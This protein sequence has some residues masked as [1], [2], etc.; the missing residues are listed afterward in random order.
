MRRGV[1][2]VASGALV[3]GAGASVGA[4][5]AHMS[6]GWA[7]EAALESAADVVAAPTAEVVLPKPVVVTRIK[8]RHV[9]P[10]PVIIRRKV[11]VRVPAAQ[12]AAPRDQAEVRTSPRSTSSRPQSAKPPTRTKAVPAP[13]KQPSRTAVAPAPAAA[14]AKTS[15]GT[16]TGT[17]SKSS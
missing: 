5:A 13:R 2:A 9:T 15:G 6:S 14:P 10:D 7:Q 11:I 8:K 17:T 1:A 12:G 4:L 16:S 3:V